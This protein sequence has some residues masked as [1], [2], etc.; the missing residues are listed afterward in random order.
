[1]SHFKGLIR[2]IITIRKFATSVVMYYCIVIVA[3]I[4]IHSGFGLIEPSHRVCPLSLNLLSAYLYLAMNQTISSLARWLLTQIGVHQKLPGRTSSRTPRGTR[5]SDKGEWLLIWVWRC[6]TRFCLSVWGGWWGL[7]VR[8]CFQIHP[9]VNTTHSLS[10]KL[11]F[12]LVL[13]I[14]LYLSP[15][16]PRQSNS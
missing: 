16:L 12:K 11:Y 4:I 9:V 3:I 5:T 7:G 8:L 10:I 15:S 13:S 2:S 6:L 1:M 14:F